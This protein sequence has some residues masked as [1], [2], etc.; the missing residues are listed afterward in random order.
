MGVLCNIYIVNQSCVHDC[1][2]PGCFA[3]AK[4]SSPNRAIGVLAGTERLWS[5]EEFSMSD[6]V[7]CH[8]QRIPVILCITEGYSGVDD[9]H[10]VSVDD[11]SN[12]VFFVS[13]SR[14]MDVSTL[15]EFAPWTFRPRDVSLP[16]KL[17]SRGVFR[18]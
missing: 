13:L 1:A 14:F 12:A 18:I 16:G 3:T 15:C 9:L 6:F 17:V 11:V 10:S 7:A 4:M 8:G 2:S 5:R